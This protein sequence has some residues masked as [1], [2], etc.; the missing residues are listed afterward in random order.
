MASNNVISEILLIA[1]DFAQRSWALKALSRSGAH[2]TSCN[3][4]AEARVH[5]AG[6]SGENQPGLII[7]QMS[8]LHDEEPLAFCKELR[9]N[10][11]TQAVPV[12]LLAETAMERAMV[13]NLG[14]KRCCAVLIPLTY[15]PFIFALPALDIELHDSILYQKPVEEQPVVSPAPA[16]KTRVQDVR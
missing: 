5:L 1:H 14:F 10:P 4:S 16:K 2:V 12:I 11:R 7:Q 8:Y 9:L 13:Q 6:V 15:G 3:S